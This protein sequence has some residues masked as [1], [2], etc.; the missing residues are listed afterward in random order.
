MA[1]FPNCC[2][3][4]L[5]EFVYRSMPFFYSHLIYGCNILGLTSK[6]NLKKM[7]ILQKGC[8]RIMTISNSTTYTNQLFIKFKVLKYCEI[9]KLQQ[10]KLRYEFLG[11]SFPDDLKCMFKLNID[12]HNPQ[13]TN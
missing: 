6:E 7:E 12:I 4:L 10:L 13:S 9:I 1:F 3:I 11:N 5:S 8:I 2:I